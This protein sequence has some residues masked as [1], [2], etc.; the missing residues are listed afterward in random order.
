MPSQTIAGHDVS[1]HATGASI[2]AT[3]EGWDTTSIPPGTSGWVAAMISDSSNT[4]YL[5][6]VAEIQ[7]GPTA[8]FSDGFESGDTSGWSSE[9]P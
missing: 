8:I 1:G 4:R 3:S 2:V 9:M 6:D 5:Y 7:F